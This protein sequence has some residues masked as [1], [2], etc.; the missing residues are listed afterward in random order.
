M[1]FIL[2]ICTN[3]SDLM[4][5][6]LDSQLWLE[7]FY[8]LSVS[9]LQS[10]SVFEIGSLVFCGFQRGGREPKIVCDRALFLKILFSFKNGENVPKMSQK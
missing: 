2:V 3:A 10:R 1:N 9:V 8:E 5:L 4:S 7:R 6:L